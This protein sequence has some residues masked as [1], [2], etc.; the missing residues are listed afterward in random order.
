MMTTMVSRCQWKYLFQNCNKF[1]IKVLFQVFVGQS[2][3]F[4]VVR[5]RSVTLQP[6]REHFL[7]MAGFMVTTDQQA[8]SL[9]VKYR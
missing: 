6:G 1:K 5:E 9:D 4:P 7:E 3:E 8:E 2:A